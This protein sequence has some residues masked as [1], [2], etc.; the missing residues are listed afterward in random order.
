MAGDLAERKLEK[1]LDSHPD[2]VDDIGENMVNMASN[3]SGESYNPKRPVKNKHQWSAIEDVALIEALMQLNNAGDLRNKNEKG[4]RP[5]HGLKLQ[6]MLEVSLPGYG[7]KAKPH[8]ESRLRT[9]QKL[10]NIVHDMLY[11]V[12]SSGFGWDSGKKL[13]WLRILCG[14]NILRYKSL[15]YYKE[16]SIILCGDRASGKDAQVPADI[17]EELDKVAVENDESIGV[18]EDYASYAQDFIFRSSEENSKPKRRKTESTKDL[19]RVI[20]EATT[21]LREELN[22]ASNR[23]SK[24][25]EY[26]EGTEKRMKINEVLTKLPGLSILERHKATRKISCDCD[27]QAASLTVVFEGTTLSMEEV[28]SLHLPPPWKVQGS[29]LYY[30]LGMISGYFLCDLM[31]I[32]SGGYFYIFDPLGL[33]LSAHPNGAPSARLF[34]L[35]D[36]EKV[37]QDHVYDSNILQ[38][39]RED[40]AFDVIASSLGAPLQGS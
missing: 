14:M 34:S 25:L 23:L 21:I 40:A 12:G 31:T 11:G 28:C 1:R 33:A 32:V 10:H 35:I 3:P 15:A 38:G 27:F 9:F 39:E 8:I 26:D 18:D 30:G 4:F 13:L 17:V 2:E 19:S 16:L 5:G 29:A 7:I 24:A 37:V 36:F 20:K 6:Q 22:N